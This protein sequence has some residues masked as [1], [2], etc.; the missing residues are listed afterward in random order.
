MLVLSRKAGQR[1][2]VGD[3][4]ISVVRI[5]RRRV[6]IGISAASD[7]R[8]RRGEI[9]ADIQE[10]HLQFFIYPNGACDGTQELITQ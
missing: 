9:P 7:I 8:I 10:P 5:G 1:L 3:V 4:E 6:R 2:I